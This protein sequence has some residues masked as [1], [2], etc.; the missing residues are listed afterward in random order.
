MKKYYVVW[1]GDTGGPLEIEAEN[2]IAAADKARDMY[3]EDFGSAAVSVFE[4][5][6]VYKTK[7]TRPCNCPDRLSPDNYGMEIG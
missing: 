1:A 4:C 7:Y 2:A 6:P 5:A 3:L